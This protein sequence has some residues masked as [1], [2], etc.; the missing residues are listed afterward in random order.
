MAPNCFM[1]S[2]RSYPGFNSSSVIL[3]EALQVPVSL[4]ILNK[5]FVLQLQFYDMF[6]K[7]HEF[8]A[9]LSPFHCNAVSNIA[10]S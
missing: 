10:S 2:A 5:L 9:S 7:C 3:A 1:L 6:K 4:E 8:E